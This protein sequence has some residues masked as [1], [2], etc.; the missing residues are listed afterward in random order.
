MRMF[1]VK[2]QLY[3]CYIITVNGPYTLHADLIGSR[4]ITMRALLIRQDWMSTGELSDRPDVS[5]RE[6]KRDNMKLW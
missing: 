1:H 2:H 5:D 4:N 3:R 6:A